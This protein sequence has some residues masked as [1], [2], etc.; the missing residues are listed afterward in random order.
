MSGQGHS[1]RAVTWYAYNINRVATLSN[2]NIN[3]IWLQYTY[4]FLQ[5]QTENRISNGINALKMAIRNEGL[6][7]E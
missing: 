2:K 1:M 3:Y 5:I 7:H 6:Y 4:F